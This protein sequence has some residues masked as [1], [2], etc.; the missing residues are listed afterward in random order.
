MSDVIYTLPELIRRSSERF[1]DRILYRLYD[2]GEIKESF[3]YGEVYEKIRAMAGLL[4]SLGVKPGDKVML[5]SENRPAWPVAYFAISFIGAVIV[6]VLIDFTASQVKTVFEHAEC[7]AVCTSEKLLNKLADAGV[8]SDFI[9]I[10]RFMHDDAC[11]IRSKNLVSV[12]YE[13]LDP[14]DV[15]E[16]DLAAILYTSGTTGRSKGVMLSHKNLALQAYECRSVFKVGPRDRLFSVLPLAHTYE[17]TIGMLFPTAY[18]CSITYISR[19]PTASVLIPALSEVRPTVMLSVPLIIEKIYNTKIKPQLVD[20]PL[21]KFKLTR[22]LALWVAGKKLLATFGGAL[23]FFGIGGAPLAPDTEDFLKSSGFPYAIGY[24]LTETAPLIAG[25]NPRNTVRGAIGPIFKNVRLRI[26]DANGNIVAGEGVKSGSYNAEG[27][28]QVKSPYVMMGYYKQ[29]ELTRSVFTEDGW[30]KTGD[31]GLLD[32][33]GRLFIKGRLKSLILGPGGENIYPEEIEFLLNLS[34]FVEESL[35]YQDEAGQLVAL[36]VLSEQAKNLL[37]AAGDG[38]DEAMHSISSGVNNLTRAAED[39]AEKLKKEVNS[40]L[41]AFSRISR[42]KLD[43]KPLE[44]T[45]T[46]KVKRFLYT[47]KNN[48]DKKSG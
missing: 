11:V 23:R 47:D 48:D 1:S 12:P 9:L 32:R 40:R 41:A 37:A 13:L 27:E 21:Y 36:V 43:D 14:A 42:I 8:E 39:F 18:G 17:C 34:D 31:I 5:I 7:A 2:D 44:K 4:T 16:D 29:P 45:A 6:P 15:K 46:H 28:I 26:V 33:R 24:G 19:P 10:D 38:V 3:S 35:V 30:F 20:H 22:P 25:S